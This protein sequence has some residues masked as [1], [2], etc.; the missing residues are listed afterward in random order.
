MIIR[1]FCYIKENHGIQLAYEFL[2]NVNKLRMESDD[3]VDDAHLELHHV[4]RAFVESILPKVKSPPQEILQKLEKE[5]ELQKLS[6]ESSMLVF[7]LGLSKLHCSLLMNGLVTDPIEEAFLNALN[8]ETQRIQEQVY[9]RPIKSHIDVL[10]KFLSEAGIQHYNPRIISDDRPRFISLS[11]FIFGEA[12]IMNEIDYLHA[13]E[14]N[15]D[16]KPVTHLIAVDI[17]SGNGL[18]LLHQVLNYLIE[19][20]KDA[21]VGLLFNAN[22]STDSFSLLFAKVFEITSSS[23]SHKKNVLEFLDQLCSLYQQNYFLT[24][25]VEVDSAQAF[26]DKICELAEA[27]GMPSKCYRSVLPE[28][29]AEKVRRRLSKVENFLYQVLGSE[30]GFN[31]VFTNGKVTHPVDESSFL[32]ADLYLLE[33]I[34]FKLKTKHIVEI[35]E[36]VK[37]QDVDHDMLTSNLISDIIMALFSSIAV[38]ERASESARFEILNDQ[39]SAIILPNE[40]SSIHIDAVL[41]PLSPTSQKV[42]GILRVLWK[43]VQP[44]M[45][46]VLNPLSP[47]ADLPLKNY[48]RYKVPSMDDFSGADSSVNDP[49][50]FLL[51]CHCPRH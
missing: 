7:K 48:Y 6:Q 42:P 38:G 21:R 15:D 17:T 14:T 43:Y 40:N 24:S 10:A 18:K 27:D 25:A 1:L 49:K 29:S 33:S 39:H 51:T 5:Q 47:L 22:K 2:S 8:V 23:Y 35:I 28:F 34:E 19:G 4:E 26:V 11:T 44:S 20:S 46:I 31:V 50:A 13:P 36:E 16:L 41:D 9:F 12:S 30:Y 37:W 3:H 32:S 45:R